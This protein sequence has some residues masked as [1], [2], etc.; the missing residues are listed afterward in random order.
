MAT[1]AAVEAAWLFYFKIRY[2]SV[3]TIN[4][5]AG[6]GRYILITRFVVHVLDN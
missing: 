4:S 1:G 2:S 6:L 5:E 3:H